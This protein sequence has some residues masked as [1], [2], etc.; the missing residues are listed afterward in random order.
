MKILDLVLK[1]RWYNMIYSGVKKEEYREIKPYWIERLEN[2]KYDIVRFRKGYT[3]I[4][5]EFSIRYI[6]KTF[7]I[8]EWGAPEDKMVYAI[9]LGK[10]IR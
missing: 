10:R 8:P 2:N 9:G 6:N 7:G 1:H 3:N 4:S 5:M